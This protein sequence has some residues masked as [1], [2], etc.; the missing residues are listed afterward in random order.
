MEGVAGAFGATIVY[1][2]DLGTSFCIA[3]LDPTLMVPR[4][5]V[6]V[7]ET[8]YSKRVLDRAPRNSF[9][10]RCARL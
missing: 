1:P 9:V 8:L 10:A 6:K 7:W 3:C 2:I 5:S 4:Y